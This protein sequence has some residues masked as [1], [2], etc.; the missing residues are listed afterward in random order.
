[1]KR[2]TRTSFIVEST[3]YL[4]RSG[5]IAPKVNE[6]CKVLMLHPVLVLKNSS[7]G[8][9][10]IRVGTKDRVRRKYIASI[11]NVMGTIDTRMLFITYAGLTKEELEDIK[12]QVQRKV[13]F[14][15]IIC[16][17]ASSAISTHCGPGTFGLLFMMK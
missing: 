1:M 4:A 16:Q 2:R 17:K 9:G 3:E 15:N 8:V 12:K 10:A 13:E 14:Q 5:R 7:L 6:L 11:L